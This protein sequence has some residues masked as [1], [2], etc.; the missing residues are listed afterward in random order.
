MSYPLAHAKVCYFDVALR[1]EKDIVKLQIPVDDLLVVGKKSNVEIAKGD[2]AVKEEES[3]D[4]LGSVELGSWLPKTFALRIGESCILD[5]E[6]D[7][8][9]KLKRHDKHIRQ[10]IWLES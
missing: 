3:E 8:H 5:L 2:L 6:L 9:S 7:L 1:C 10:K 4:N